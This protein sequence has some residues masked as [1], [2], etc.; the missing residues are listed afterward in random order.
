M[1]SEELFIKHVRKQHLQFHIPG[2]CV[3]D[4][5]TTNILSS[6]QGNWG[7]VLKDLQLVVNSELIKSI[8]DICMKQGI[9]NAFNFRRE[10]VNLKKVAAHVYEQLKQMELKLKQLTTYYY[11]DNMSNE[12]AKLGYKQSLRYADISSS[13][14]HISGASRSMQDIRIY[15]KA[16][17]CVP[18]HPSISRLD[19]LQKLPFGLKSFKILS[20]AKFYLNKQNENKKGNQESRSCVNLNKEVSEQSE[21]GNGASEIT[22]PDKILNNVLMAIQTSIPNLPKHI[23]NY[24]KYLFVARG[25]SKSLS[26]LEE[27]KV[28]KDHML[29][30][31]D[32]MKELLN[33]YLAL[34]KDRKNKQEVERSVDKYAFQANVDLYIRLLRGSITVLDTMIDCI[35]SMLK[36]PNRRLFVASDLKTSNEMTFF[37]PSNFLQSISS[38]TAIGS[39]ALKKHQPCMFL[40]MELEGWPPKEEIRPGING[41]CKCKKCNS[42]LGSMWINSN[43]HICLYCENQLRNTNIKIIKNNNEVNAVPIIMDH[44]RILTER[45]L[46]RPFVS[47]DKMMISSLCSDFDVSSMCMLVPHPYTADNAQYF[48]ENVCT[49]T[50]KVTLGIV[51]REN[52]VLIG[53]ISLDDIAISSDDTKRK[54][55]SIG[56]WLGKQYWGRGFMTEAAKAI[57]S[58][59]FEKLHLNELNGTCWEENNKSGNVMKKVGFL[60]LTK[61]PNNVDP[62]APCLARGMKMFPRKFFQLTQEHYNMIHTLNTSNDGKSCKNKKILCPFKNHGCKL[63]KAF[64]LHANRCFSCDHWSCPKCNLIR[65]NGMSVESMVDDVISCR[66]TDEKVYLGGIFLDFDRTFCS[67]KSGNSPLSKKGKIQQDSKNANNNLATDHTLDQGLLNLVFNYPTLVHIVTRN[68]HVDDIRTFLNI[69][70]VPQSVQIRSVKK[71]RTT[72]GIV[73]ENILR[74]KKEELLLSTTTKMSINGGNDDGENDLSTQMATDLN[75]AKDHHH[76]ENFKLVGIFVDDDIREHLHPDMIKIEENIGIDLKKILFVRSVY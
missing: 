58:Y 60:H 67:T 31:K 21:D 53:C 35:I 16:I 56:Y 10:A 70:N 1:L 41:R 68:S 12:R 8:D 25:V 64:C 63:P 59:G 75:I 33:K 17:C 4:I 76:H 38:V 66:Q 51:L 5:N 19:R 43:L 71:E 32:D 49:A 37:A 65:G 18:R 14:T 36:D 30:I 44:S 2:P 54:T 15:L 72:K 45:L 40:D 20:Q 57:V 29:R 52:Q 46:L 27:A 6:P 7:L 55:A 3:Y 34:K 50:E 73:I 26:I 62:Y 22:D 39:A 48:L 9:Q 24:L 13:M 28:F 11:T 74:K 61:L 23:I 47:E 42:K 69:K